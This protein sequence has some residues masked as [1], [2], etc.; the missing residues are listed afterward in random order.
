MLHAYLVDNPRLNSP[1]FIKI[2]SFEIRAFLKKCGRKSTRTTNATEI[3]A[4]A[5]LFGMGS[6]RLSAS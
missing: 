1:T 3:A 5:V 2:V 4:L 6:E